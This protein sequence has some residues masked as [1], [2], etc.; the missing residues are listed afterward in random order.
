MRSHITWSQLQTRTVQTR[1][2]A[3]NRQVEA[4]QALML[5]RI[6]HCNT[7]SFILAPRVAC[8]ELLHMEELRVGTP[9]VLHAH[10]CPC[11]TIASLCVHNPRG[12]ADLKIKLSRLCSIANRSIWRG[13]SSPSSRNQNQ[14]IWGPSCPGHPNTGPGKPAHS[15]KWGG[16]EGSLWKISEWN[17]SFPIAEELVG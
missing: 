14:T 4:L 16:G 5:E 13:R 15:P 11:P 6:P 9:P 2:Q 10:L 1:V 17:R 12:R 3:C 7:Q 8:T